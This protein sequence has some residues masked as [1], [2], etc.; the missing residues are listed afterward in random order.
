LSERRK[1]NRIAEERMSKRMLGLTDDAK[2]KKGSGKT[3]SG[4]LSNSQWVKV[5]LLMGGAGIVLGGVF[6]WLKIQM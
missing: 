2:S 4:F 6:S 5:G 3:A 1:K